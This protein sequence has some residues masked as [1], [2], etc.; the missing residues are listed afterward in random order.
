MSYVYECDEWKILS[1]D[2]NI[3]EAS[4]ILMKKTTPNNFTMEI[5]DRGNISVNCSISLERRPSYFIYNLIVP[6]LV[7]VCLNI[8]TVFIPSSAIEKPEIQ[9]SVFL[10]FA[11]YQLLL[12]EN[13][14]KSEMVPYIAYYIMRSLILT[15]YNLFTTTIVLK[16]HRAHKDGRM[17][18][19]FVH[20]LAIH[21]ILLSLNSIKKAW[22]WMI[23]KISYKTFVNP[24]SNGCI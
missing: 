7:I 13:T 2:T 12:A 10:A 9:F 22:H 23:L 11:F 8:V 4:E 3:A 21:P 18:P 20:N 14:P 6:L 1:V 19:K 24:I 17:L 15:A 5:Y 16:V